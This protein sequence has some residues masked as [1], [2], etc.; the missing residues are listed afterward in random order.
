[1]Q[2]MTENRVKLTFFDD[3][4]VDFRPGTTRRWFKPELFTTI[5]DNGCYGALI[6]DSERKKYRIFQHLAAEE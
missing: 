2:T 1:M 4:W 5:Y 6:Y 3:F